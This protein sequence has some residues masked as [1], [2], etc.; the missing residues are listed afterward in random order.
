[1]NQVYVW[2]RGE[3]LLTDK[4]PEFHSLAA[5]LPDGTVIDGEI[6]PWKDGYP[7]AFAVMQTRIGRKNLSAKSLSD[8]PLVMICYDLLE[9]NGIDIRGLPL[10]TRRERLASLLSSDSLKDLLLLSPL[11][12]LESWEQVAAFRR[13]AREE[14]C[15]GLMIKRKTSLYETG[16]RRGNWWK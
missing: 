11:V 14:Y 6:I 8:A 2:S 12:S 3:E 15:E 5:N 1:N 7:M 13:N 4:F 10:H 9:H 16:R